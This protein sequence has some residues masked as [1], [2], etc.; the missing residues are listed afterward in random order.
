VSSYDERLVVPWWWLLGGLGLTGLIAAE[1]HG[2]APGLRAVLPYAVGL[3][4]IVVLLAI[5]SRGRVRVQDE[6]L[7][8]P[9]ARIGLHH[10]GD[11]AVLDRESLRRQTGP[12]A[13]RRAF[14]VSRPWLHSAVRVLLTDPE[15]DTPYWVI[16][17]R[18][19]EQLAAALAQHT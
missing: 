4:L 3:P 12:M 11:V 19:P 2:G 7:F 6:V 14:L 10:L 9:G 1:V 8:V 16:G 18:R 15:D 5:G 13:D 17:T